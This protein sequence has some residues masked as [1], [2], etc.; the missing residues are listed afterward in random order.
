[1]LGMKGLLIIYVSILVLNLE[2]LGSIYSKAKLFL[3]ATFYSSHCHAYLL[4]VKFIYS[5]KT[6]T[7]CKIFIVYW[8]VTKY[9]GQ[10]YGADLENL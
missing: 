5:E 1:M 3:I 10:I 7:F 2:D 4:A 8:T 9:I 6:I